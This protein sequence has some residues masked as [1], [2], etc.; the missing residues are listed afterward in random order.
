LY[1][2][3]DERWNMTAIFDLSYFD[4]NE[5]DRSHFHKL[6]AFHNTGFAPDAAAYI[7]GMEQVDA[8]RIINRFTNLSLLKPVP[9]SSE[10]YRLHDLLDEYT[11]LKLSQSGEEVQAKN[12]VANWLADLFDKHFT[13]DQTTAPE[14]KLEMD[15]LERSAEWL[16][17]QKDG[18]GLANITRAARN[19]FVVLSLHNKWGQWSGLALSFGV[20]DK[21]REANVLQAIGDVQQFRKENDAA[22]ESYN[23]ALK[24]FKAVGDRLGEANVYLSLGGSKRTNKDFVGAR[25]DFQNAFNTYKLIGDQYSQARALYRLGDC[26]SDEERFLE[27]LD[28]YEQAAQLWHSIGVNDLVESILNPRVEEARKHL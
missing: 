7:W 12:A 6:A 19:W 23:E 8:D 3:G 2:A 18:N 1:A 11:V 10:R 17:S 25:N 13:E 27:A 9:G 15:N 26:M 20:E 21:K 14:V 28:Y 22:L 5:A 4:L 24:L 16:I